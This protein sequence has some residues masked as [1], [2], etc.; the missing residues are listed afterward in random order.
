MLRNRESQFAMTSNVTMKRSTF[1][2]SSSYT[3][4]FNVGDLIPFYVDEV[5]PGDTF[6]INTSY[7][8]RL[9]TLLTP[10]YGNMYIDLYWFYVPNRIIWDHWV[11]LQGENTQGPWYD[12]TE[13]T[14]PIVW[15]P[16]GGWIEGTI[17]D[18]MGI[19]T[20]VNTGDENEEEINA[21]P[22][23]AYCKIVNDWFRDENLQDYAY[24]NK[25]D[26]GK[27]GNNG[28]HYQTDLAGGGKPFKACK[29]HDYFTSCLPEPQKGPD[30]LI[31]Q[32][33]AIPIYGGEDVPLPDRK[34]VV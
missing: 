34:S 22:F 11:N 18:Y 13:Y 15:S 5:L 30:V 29:Y 27:N 32:N 12:D 8:A 2:R 26:Q 28:D 4:T 25:G 6:S 9:Q 23:R 19:P 16:E 20:H 7:V 17:A 3:T 14:V 31:A 33:A 24:F 21:L 10:V 1:D